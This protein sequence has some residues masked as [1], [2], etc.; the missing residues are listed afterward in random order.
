M[1]KFILITLIIL[2]GCAKQKIT[3]RDVG[4]IPPYIDPDA[5]VEVV[6]DTMSGA[7]TTPEVY[8]GYVSLTNMVVHSTDVWVFLVPVVF[9]N[10]VVQ[11]GVP[12]QTNSDSFITLA[13]MTNY[14]EVVP[15]AKYSLTT[16]LNSALVQIS[17]VSNFVINTSNDLWG[18]ML[19][20]GNT[21]VTNM[22]N[23]TDTRIDG[24]SNMLLDFMDTNYVGLSEWQ[25]HSSDPPT[26]KEKGQQ[27]F[28]TDT[29]DLWI[30]TNK[31]SSTD[32]V[33]LFDAP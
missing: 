12:I 13:T 10:I 31:S 19:D 22:A 29:G 24:T 11:E 5:Y 20:L 4:I 16:S 8:A 27:W 21:L 14:L 26:S 6:G 3:S 23:Y 25:I 28:E 18:S 1:K 32:W 9:S 7:L 15:I 2:A 17:N 30:S 33:K